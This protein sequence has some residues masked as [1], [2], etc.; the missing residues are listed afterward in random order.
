M[1]PVTKNVQFNFILII[2]MTELIHLK[3]TLNAPFTF[4]Q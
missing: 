2:K 4:A 1:S 3:T